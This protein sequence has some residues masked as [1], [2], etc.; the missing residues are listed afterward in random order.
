MGEV[1]QLPWYLP[2]QLV[3]SKEEKAGQVGEVAQLWRGI[4]AVSS[5]G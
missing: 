5:I 3:E 1:A 2:A 4:G